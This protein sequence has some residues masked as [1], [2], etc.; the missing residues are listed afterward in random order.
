MSQAALTNTLLVE[1]EN[2]RTF[3]SA[4]H[5][6]FGGSIMV[7]TGSMGRKVLTGAQPLGKQIDKMYDA[8]KKVFKQ[9]DVKTKQTRVC[10]RRGMCSVLINALCR[11]PLEITRHYM[12]TK[13]NMC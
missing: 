1:K 6:R 7:Q 10:Y 8:N 12:T 2:N 13:P 11:I 3:N 9:K 4:R 5:S